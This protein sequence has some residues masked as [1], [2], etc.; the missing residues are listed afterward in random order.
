MKLLYLFLFFTHATGFF[1]TYHHPPY[2]DIHNELSEGLK[3]DSRKTFEGRTDW[4]S[5]TRFG[6]LEMFNNKKIVY[7]GE[8]KHNKF[9]IDNNQAGYSGAR[10]FSVTF[11]RSSGS[12]ATTFASLTRLNRVL[13]YQVGSVYLCQ[14]SAL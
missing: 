6:R 1:K 13:V 4:Y 14:F 5:L 9:G 8:T 3:K 11:I 12:G 7:P 2:Q 10:V